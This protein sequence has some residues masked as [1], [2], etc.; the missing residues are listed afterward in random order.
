MGW[1]THSGLEAY[2]LLAFGD[3]RH[4][5]GVGAKNRT[6]DDKAVFTNLSGRPPPDLINGCFVGLG[7]ILIGF[8]NLF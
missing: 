8:M 5:A 7:L 2:R 6:K 1:F 3:V 4:V